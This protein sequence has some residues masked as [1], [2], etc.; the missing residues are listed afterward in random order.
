MPAA[1]IVL[2]VP[3]ILIGL[4]IAAAVVVVVVALIALVRW[5]TGS[6]AAPSSPPN[7]EYCDTLEFVRSD[8]STD[9]FR[10]TYKYV[11]NGVEYYVTYNHPDLK[12]IDPTIGRACPTKIDLH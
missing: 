12:K 6:T 3:P 4:L 9:V 5:I 7:P 2:S 8:E 10:C 1:P 11:K